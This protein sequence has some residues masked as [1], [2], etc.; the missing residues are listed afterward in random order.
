MVVKAFLIILALTFML[1]FG[2]SDVVRRIAG[3]DYVVKIG[4]VKIGPMEFKAEKAR[5]IGMLHSQMMDVDESKLTV[6]ILHQLIWE[7]LVDQASKKYGIVVSDET[8]K[9]YIGG[10]EVFRDKEGRFNANLLR[11]FLRRLQVPETMFLESSKRSVVDAIIKYPLTFIS[12]ATCMDYYV[13]AFREKR[14]LAIVELIPDRFKV[15][16]VPNPG[17]LKG[18]YSENPELFMI[19][20]ARTFQILTLQESDI[21]KTVKVEEEEVRD[22]YEHSSER[23]ER[24]YEEMRNELGEGLRQERIQSEV[25][26]KTRKIEDALMAGDNV[27]DV[28]QKNG[29]HVIKVESV[30]L[31]NRDQKGTEALKQPYKNSVLAVAFS[32]EEGTDSSFSEDIDE[33]GNKIYWA[34]HLEKIHPRHLGD[35]DDMEAQVLKEWLKKERRE[36]ALKKAG[37]IVDKVKSGERLEKVAKQN[38]EKVIVTQWFDRDGKL[39]EKKD[40]KTSAQKAAGKEKNTNPE[41]TVVLPQSYQR[42]VQEVIEDVFS[43]EEFSAGIKESSGSVYVYQILEVSHP[44][45]IDKEEGKKF[46]QELKSSIITDMFQQLVSYLSKIYE[47]KINYDMLKEINENVDSESFKE[48]F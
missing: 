28:A 44:K 5:R 31:A 33:K 8:M 14:Q 3:K 36:E 21:G 48:M 13:R 10:M 47:I 18:F 7:N 15:L 26:E 9:K 6:S 39:E 17:I 4:N 40:E 46:A 41:N 11:G 22:A 12:T 34:V 27:E 23:E 37:H 20:E 1:F 24:S 30:S 16:D 2:I 42:V 19:D 38:K 32:L 45:E 35:Y 29:L 43:Q 25:N